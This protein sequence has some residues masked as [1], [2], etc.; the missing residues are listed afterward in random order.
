MFGSDNTMTNLGQNFNSNQD[1]VTIWILG[2]FHG[3]ENTT[4]IIP[5]QD[6]KLSTYPIKKYLNSFD[7]TRLKQRNNVVFFKV[8]GRYRSKIGISSQ[9]SSNIMATYHPEFNRLTVVKFSISNAQQYPIAVESDVPLNSVGDITNIYN[10]GGIKSN[11]SATPFFF[12]LE[13]AAAMK[14]LKHNES[15]RH[16]HDTFHFFGKPSQLSLLTQQLLALDIDD[17]N[18][19]FSSGV[20]H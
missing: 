6:K 20:N 5:V 17:I 4:A 9:A 3:T 8:D 1:A 18:A 16:Q 11:N 12:E 7:N 15:I 19:V 10:H 13:S 2:T 14:P